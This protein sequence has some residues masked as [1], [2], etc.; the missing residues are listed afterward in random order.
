MSRGVWVPAATCA[1]AGEAGPECG[2]DRRV[3]VNVVRHL[4]LRD[5]TPVLLRPL[6]VADAALYPDCLSEI[7]PDD[8]RLRYFAAM[9]EVSPELIDKLVHYDPCLLYTS[10]AAD[11]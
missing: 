6:E 4:K 9:R 1:R 3:A 10:D 7:T 5:G 8:L 2:D 11:E